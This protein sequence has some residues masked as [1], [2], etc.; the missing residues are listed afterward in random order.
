MMTEQ[1]S[2][3][4]FSTLAGCGAGGR[5]DMS[6]SAEES[7]LEQ[8]L[9]VYYRVLSLERARPL[10]PWLFCLM[11]GTDIV[12]IGYG[13]LRHCRVSAEFL[14]GLW[15]R[16]GLWQLVVCENGA[17]SSALPPNTVV[18]RAT[19]NQEDPAKPYWPMPRWP[20][21]SNNDR[22]DRDR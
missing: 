21:G 10:G 16:P 14:A 18:E 13:T 22:D 9:K 20:T 3:K 8:G 2:M 11:H 1:A 17:G 12:A 15:E 7:R 6:A 5:G 4:Q 19:P